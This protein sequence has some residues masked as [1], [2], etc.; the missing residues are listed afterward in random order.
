MRFLQWAV[1]AA[2]IFTTSPAWAYKWQINDDSY[3]GIDYL[4]QAH[5]Q[6]TENGAP[7]KEDWSKDLF[8]R[9]SRFVL[10]GG[11][12]KYLTFF[13]E[14]DQ[15]NFGK[16]G[17]WNAPFFVQDA[18]VNF[19]IMDEFQV[20][21]GL[22]LL[23]FTRHSFM[24]AVGVNALDYHL[25]MIKYPDGSTKVWRDAGVQVRGYVFEQKFQYR[26]GVFGG[27]QNVALQKDAA[28][29]G[30]PTA[31]SNP[32]DWPRVTG[33]LRYAILGTETDFFPK[34]IYFAKDPVLSLGV[35]ADAVP[36]SV[37][38]KAAVLDAAG[39]VTTPATIGTHIAAAGDVFLDLP[40]N[41]DNE[42][43]FQ[44]A[45]LYYADGQ[46]VK[47]GGIGVLSEV[48]YRWTFLEPVLQFDW[49]KSDGKEADYL[50][51]RGGLNFWLLKH[52]ASFKIE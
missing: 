1:A 7:S 39:K 3:V 32:Q 37:L 16:N 22:I 15:V 12:T 2:V 25:A 42:L 34:G 26:L 19:K 38:V 28:G 20:D 17:D 6:V 43:V 24:S 18:Y 50:G 31:F 49:F 51:L 40:F 33:H 13:M 44:G 4:L 52:G 14:T 23:P 29:K 10:M 47:S 41:E 11:L 45:L 36:D 9:R 21:A 27:S 46:G 35:G 5:A 8:I 30:V 48:G